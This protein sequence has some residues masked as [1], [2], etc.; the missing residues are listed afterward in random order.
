MFGAIPNAPGPLSSMLVGGL[1]GAGVG[2]GTGYLAEKILPEKWRKKNL[3]RT[4]AIAGGGLG[5]LPGAGVGVINKLTG[6][7]FNSRELL[8]AGYD[9]PK[10][11][12]KPEAQY[13]YTD[14]T[15]RSP[16][17]ITDN[18][19][20]SFAKVAL[21]SG[22]GIAGLPR[23]DVNAFNQVIWKDPRVARPMS[24]M[25]RAAA[26][27]L[28]T[29]AANL[30]GRRDTRFVTPMDIGRITAGMGTGYA[31]GALVG[32]ALGILTGMPSATQNKLKSTGVW[33]GIVSNIIPVAFGG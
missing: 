16:I 24:P 13:N 27:G 33:A 20:L 3:R 14:P 31:S 32:K 21:L 25:T 6:R 4:L 7:P 2:Y 8:Q 12:P 9:F 23:I 22:T 5:M 30:P 10:I 17:R 28:L 19:K 29:S 15:G 11:E 26:S 18:T 1:A